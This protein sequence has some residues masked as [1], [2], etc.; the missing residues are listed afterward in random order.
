M[1]LPAI[2]AVFSA[3]VNSSALV[4]L[5]DKTRSPRAMVAKFRWTAPG[6]LAVAARNAR[7]NI[8]GNWCTSATAAD[9]F[10]ADRK[11]S[12]MSR[13]PPPLESCNG[14]Q[15]NN[16]VETWPVITRTGMQSLFALTV[17]VRACVAPGPDVTRATMDTLM[18]GVL[19]TLPTSQSAEF[20]LVDHHARLLAA[21]A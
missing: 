4:T 21:A 2:S 7:R 14:P 15:P 11:T 8:T 17:A 16:E 13:T 20:T 5:D 12:T 1:W 6:T 19:P 3:I 18:D 9:N 10:V